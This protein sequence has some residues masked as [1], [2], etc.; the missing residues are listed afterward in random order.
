MSH[1]TI[2]KRINLGFASMILITGILGG[3]GYVEVAIINQKADTVVE[4]LA[5]GQALCWE[6]KQNVDNGRLQIY[7]YLNAQDAAEK[8]RL[9]EQQKTISLRTT[10]MFD[11]LKLLVKTREGSNSIEKILEARKEH[12]NAR[13]RVIA[14]SRNN[15]DNVEALKIVNA[16]FKTTADKYCALLDDLKGMASSQST[17]AMADIRSAAQTTALRLLIGVCASILVGSSIAFLISRRVNRHLRLVAQGLEEN[18]EQ[19]ASA[20]TQVS[21]ASQSVAEGAS[22]QAAA[23][24]ET[25]SSL[26]EMSSMARQNN[27]NATSADSLARE[28][29]QAA[30]AGA[31]EMR[32]LAVAMGDIKSSADDISKIIKHIDEIA[33]QTNILAL[34]AAVEAARAGEAGMGF[35]VVADEVRSLAQRAAQSARETSEKISAALEK[36]DQGVQ[37]TN[38]VAL[39]LKDIVVKIRQLEK[40]SSDVSTASTEQS[41]GIAQIT[42]GVSEMDRATQSNAAS[43]EESASAA[44]QLTAQAEQ[45]LDSVA[46][47]LS[48]VDGA[49]TTP[50]APATRTFVSTDNWRNKPATAAPRSPA[51]PNTNRRRILSPNTNESSNLLI[52][53]NEA[54]MTTGFPE[55]DAEHMELIHMINQLHVACEKGSGKE[56]LGEMIS[57]LG[58]YVRTHFKNEEEL[59]SHLKCEASD[60]NKLAHRQ[61]LSDFHKLAAKYEAE[62]ESTVILLG[63][64]QLVAKWLV[65]HICSVDVKL[66]EYAE[67]ENRH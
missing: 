26:E 27:Q 4:R 34:N 16:E 46:E 40:L 50:N 25:S 35:A 51:I 29:K 38:K 20:A 42:S 10:E 21:S 57:F 66:R 64:K 41:Q 15:A 63:L 18:A 6:I 5:P 49:K 1:W 61:F 55:T 31:E 65:D 58:D 56:Q 45:L 67:Q 39:A 36:T 14:A 62:G 54:R 12:A 19:V 60:E 7:Q 8:E 11:N 32:D 48:L 23:L 30:D 24:E 59:M 28:A 33:F 9:T 52:Q 13:E 37:I 22:E 53:W 47:L 3:M 17:T 43:A 2:G 44:K